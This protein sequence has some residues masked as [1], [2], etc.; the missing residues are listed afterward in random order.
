MFRMPLQL[1]WNMKH[2]SI[3]LFLARFSQIA[4]LLVMIFW[5]APATSFSHDSV[6][7]VVFLSV[8]GSM[9]LSATTELLYTYRAG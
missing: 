7:L 9:L 4:F 6:P 2:V 8:L 3:A 1:H 5:V